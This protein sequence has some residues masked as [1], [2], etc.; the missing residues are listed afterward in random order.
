MLDTNLNPDLIFIKLGGSLI[1]DKDRAETADI[2]MLAD[3]LAEISRIRGKHPNLKL[4]LGHGSG[5]FGHHA[6]RLAGTRNGVFTPAD[7]QGYQKVWAS[8][9]RLNQIV[10]EACLQAQL[11]VLSFPP[12]ASVVTYQHEIQSWELAPLRSALSNGLIPLVYGDV[13]ID[14]ALG[15]T[16]LSTEDL[17]F[18]LALALKPAKILLAGEEEA[19]FA[20]FPLNQQPLPFLSK[21][22]DNADFLQGSAS[23]DVTGGMLS[24]VQLMQSLCRRLPGMKAV[25]FSGRKPRNLADCLDGMIIGTTIG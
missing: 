16:I 7:W 25:I 2:A 9:R 3:L 4:L 5:S 19:V 17:F 21:D 20:D 1:T 15:G 12:S 22:A 8:A 14:R 13:V 11:P 10:V 6:A 24:K 23:L 18:H